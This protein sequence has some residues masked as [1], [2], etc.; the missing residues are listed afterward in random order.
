V[1]GGVEEGG[2]DGWMGGW[3]FGGGGEGVEGLE[4]CGWVL[5]AGCWREGELE[6]GC[7]WGSL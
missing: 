4:R 3:V 6:G 2:V 1:G 7:S 5:D